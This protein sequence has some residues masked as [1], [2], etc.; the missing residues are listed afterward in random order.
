MIVDVVQSPLAPSTPRAFGIRFALAFER[1]RGLGVSLY[2]LPDSGPRFSDV[3]VFDHSLKTLLYLDIDPNTAIMRRTAHRPPSS[4]SLLATCGSSDR[5]LRS[6]TSCRIS[7]IASAPPRRMSSPCPAADKIPAP[8][9][10]FL[11][12]RVLLVVLS[13]SVRPLAL[14]GLRAAS[15]PVLCHVSYTP[16][17][18]GVV[19][20]RPRTR[21][22]AR[23]SAVA[24]PHR[25]EDPLGRHTR[26]SHSTFTLEGF[27][28]SWGARR[29]GTTI[30]G[31]R[32]GVGESNGA[33]DE[34]TVA[35]A[36]SRVGDGSK[37]DRCGCLISPRLPRWLLPRWLP[38]A[39]AGTRS[40]GRV[41]YFCPAC[42]R[43]RP[44]ATR[45]TH[46]QR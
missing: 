41:R 18:P 16:L 28:A 1:Q 36:G 29:P 22:R 30:Y 25:Q 38:R 20:P 13:C 31:G 35:A 4:A 6:Q 32:G 14:A 43:R 34:R 46:P 7:L 8:P 39:T 9:L 26:R 10:H 19:R 12:L 24:I 2:E 23:G 45:C 15:P 11:F 44:R 27:E 37:H 40:P 5:N 17:I 33:R 3:V 42:R 21:V